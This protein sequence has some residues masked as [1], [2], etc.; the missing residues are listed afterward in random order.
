MFTIQ[1]TKMYKCG[2]DEPIEQARGF[3][4]NRTKSELI[5]FTTFDKAVEYLT[6]EMGYKPVKDM[7]NKFIGNESTMSGGY[8]YFYT[9]YEIK[10]VE[11]Q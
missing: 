4:I 6:N 5:V 3:I 9:L 1:F 7:E 10:G 8:E 11:V 2:R